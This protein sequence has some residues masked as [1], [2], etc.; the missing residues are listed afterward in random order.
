MS[1]VNT[2]YA[3]NPVL[4]SHLFSHAEALRGTYSRLLT[5]R[6][7]FFYLKRTPLFEQRINDWSC[8]DMYMLAERLIDTSNIVGYSWVMER[9]AQ[10]GIHFHA[11]FYLN[12]H[13]HQKY[14]PTAQDALQ[15]WSCLTLGQGYAH[16][17]DPG[18]NNYPVNG[19]G[20]FNYHHEQRFNELYYTLSYLA[21]EEQKEGL[22]C[23]GLSDVP[24]PDGRGR[25]R[26]EM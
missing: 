13:L 10:H 4:L 14:Y 3:L 2:N 16:I 24:E 15:L 9:T 21:K 20:K 1:N 5:F 23:Y 7:D 17:C 22:Y 11:M 12:G 6:M 25:P 26:K 19:Q 8:R 18:N